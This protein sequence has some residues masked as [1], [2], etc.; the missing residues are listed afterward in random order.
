METLP[1]VLCFTARSSVNF[2]FPAPQPLLFPTV[3]PILRTHRPISIG[4]HTVSVLRSP[5]PVTEPAGEEILLSFFKER[6]LN[7][8]FISKALDIL[9]RREVMESIDVDADMSVDA[10]QRTEEVV[11]RQYDGGFLKLK[12]THEWV[13]GDNSAPI[14]RKA[15]TKALQDDSERRK[16]LNLLKYEALKREML[17]LSVGIGTACS[18]YCLLALSVQA[19]ISYA[20]GVF[21]SCLYLLLLYQH[22]DNLCME[23][24]P[25]IFRQKK[26]KKIGIRS[27]DLRAFLERS[28]KGSSLAL[29]SPRLV[30]PA[31][32][33][34]LWILSHQHFAR[35]FFDFQLVPAMMGLFAYKAAALVQ[36]YRDNEDLKFIFENSGDS[37][38]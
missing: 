3:A 11:E 38:D 19:A 33:F 21:F 6:E 7:G 2:P 31:A 5:H 16:R 18:G 10:P 30:I 14:N 34:G 24:V 37:S 4:L 20:V 35:D 29:S 36:V 22:A 15:I 26:S 12:K 27:E 8:D 13:L 32:I 9:W 25:Q 28:V 17:L 1:R 23:T